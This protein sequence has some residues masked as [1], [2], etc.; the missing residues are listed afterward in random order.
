[1]SILDSTRR[2][3]RR[4]IAPVPDAIPAPRFGERVFD[5]SING[6]TVTAI[7]DDQGTNQI[8]AGTGE[9]S[10][11]PF[12]DFR[13]VALNPAFEDCRIYMR[14]WVDEAA[15]RPTSETLQKMLRYSAPLPEKGTSSELVAFLTEH[16][17]NQTVELVVNVLDSPDERTWARPTL[18]NRTA[19]ESR[20][21]AD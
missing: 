19:L 8:V 6:Q 2:I 10:G 12:L 9:R 11:K 17:K 5:E 16:L 20:R 15:P 4:S 18:R 14:L 1:M 21:L 13:F 3:I 7:L